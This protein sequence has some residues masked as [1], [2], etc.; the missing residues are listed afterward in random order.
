MYKITLYALFC[1]FIYSCSVIIPLNNL[2]EPKGEYLIGTDIFSWE[3][4]SRD[5]WFTKN[6]IDSR[7]IVV[8]IWYPAKE[9]SDSLYPYMD[10]AEIRLK[11]LSKQ[12][13]VPEFAMKH[14]KDIKGNSY[15]KA[16]PFSNKKFP[17]ILFSHGLG[18]T[19]TQN[20]INIE[21]LVS[22]GYIVVAPD[23]TYDASITIFDDG[24]KK[25]FDSG[26][27]VSELEGN[28]VTEKV[29]WETRLPQI[30]TRAGDIKF[31]IDKLQTMKNNN[32]YDSINFN[33]IGIFGHSFGG[34][35]SVV[36]SWNDSRIS[37]CFN[38]DGWFE[39][40]VDNIINN[41]LKIPFCYIGQEDW[42]ENSRNYNRV[43][44][45]FNNCQSD[46]YFIKI[47]NTKHFDYADL[48]YITKIGKAF[49]L[50]G[51]SV[52]KDFTMEI[53]KVILGFFNEYLKNDLSNWAEDLTKN[54]DTIIK[55]K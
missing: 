27:P 39:P 55:F 40:I 26:L 1:F 31:I 54:Y 11:A 14:A 24:T 12:L 37:A 36:S 22:N 49:K 33:K 10:N 13:G 19:K 5:E 29:F 51:K 45:F 25:E 18:G 50:S 21:E 28:I 47:K 8:Q 2:P 23:H 46:T 9:V 35:T 6:K 43:Y 3:D 41:G 30:N 38:L 34:A 44:S 20:S 4:T 42:G 32:L 15:F 16:T 7:K 52:D 48:P 17:L 53:N